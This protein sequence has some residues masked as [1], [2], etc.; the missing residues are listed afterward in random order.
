MTLALKFFSWLVQMYKISHNI[1]LKKLPSLIKSH[2]YISR[3]NVLFSQ[4]IS[5]RE[6]N[7]IIIFLGEVI[8]S[9]SI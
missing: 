7:R 5:E 2:N 1:N 8:F 3:Q 6:L 9:H 4:S